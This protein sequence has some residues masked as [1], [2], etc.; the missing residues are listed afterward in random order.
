MRAAHPTPSIGA[1]STGN[2]EHPAP[3][4][5]GDL[6]G[7]AAKDEATEK[8][9]TVRTQ[10]DQVD[11]LRFRRGN[12]RLGRVPFPDEERRPCARGSGTSNDGLNGAV[13]PRALLIDAPQERAAGKAQPSRVDHAENDQLG[14][15]VRGQAD[16]LLGGPRGRLREIRGQEDST[17]ANRRAN[18]RRIRRRLASRLVD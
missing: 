11:I 12:D 9:A 7:D 16:R 14:T 18:E 10:H 5:L 15:T 4:V 6:S 2:D 13:D 17:R 8:A 3:G 1:R